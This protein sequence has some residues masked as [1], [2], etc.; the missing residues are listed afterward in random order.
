MGGNLRGFDARNV[1]EMN[2]FEP[3]PAGKYMAAITE[4]AMKPTKAGDG[5]FLE[6]QFQVLEGEYRGRLLWARLNLD[7]KND[8]TAKIARAQLAEVCRATNVLTPND[9]AELHN[10]PIQITVKLK[11]RED[12][13]DL[14]NEVAGYAKKPTQGQAPQAQTDT[15]PWRR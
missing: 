13:G 11:K 1:Q 14:V 2:D 12:T 7:N 15:P 6:L 3:I 5:S 9:S 10:L 4:S 8:L